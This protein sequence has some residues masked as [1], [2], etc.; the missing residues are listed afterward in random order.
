[1]GTFT[2][3]YCSGF[4]KACIW[5][6]C[7]FL[8][9][10]VPCG[11]AKAAE[12]TAPAGKETQSLDAESIMQWVIGKVSDGEMDIGDEE[13]IRSAIAEG[14][15]E[16]GVTLNET[17][18]ERIV[19]VLQ[20]I[21]SLGLSAEEMLDQAQELYRKYGADV[22]NEANEIINDAVGDAVKGAAEGFFQSIVEA[23]KDFF[24][25]LFS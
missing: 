8:M 12:D 5:F 13:S 21:D 10:A 11:C 20:S 3:G 1:M 24:K 14:E 23:V 19:T 6:L 15:Q 4:R 2:D 17:E 25:D 22:V 7:L 16:F 9:L 18:K